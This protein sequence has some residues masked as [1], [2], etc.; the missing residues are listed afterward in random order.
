[1]ISAECFMQLRR[2]HDREHL[3]IPQIAHV[4]KLNVKTVAAWVPL[5]HY[6]PRAKIKRPSKLDAH[7]ATVTRLLDQCG[8]SAVQVFQRLRTQGYTG[9]YSI[10][11]DYIREIRPPRHPAF[12]TL[13]YAPG[14]CA[15]V[16][17]GH[18]GTIAVG[19]THRKLSFLVVVLCYSRRMYVEFT[20]AQALEHFL[21]A[22]Q[23]ALLYFGA[24]PQT[25]LVDN[26]KTAVLEHVPGLPP[27]FHPRFLEFARHF[28]FS[29]KA[30]GVRQPQAK[31]RVENGVGYVKKNFLNGRDLAGVSAM[32]L[33][34]REWLDTVANVRVHRETHQTPNARF[35]AEKTALLPLNP[36]PADTGVIE[37][38]RVSHQC[39]VVLDTNRYS[40]PSKYASS[41]LSL[42]R[43]DERLWLY[44]Q[45]KLVADHVRSYDRRQ[46]IENPDHVRELLRHKHGAQDHVL[47]QRFLELSP[48]AEIFHR[49]ITA[50]ELNAPHHVRHIMAL[51][52][53]YP[54]EQV[55]QA[56]ENAHAL[57]SY[58][59]EYIAVILSMRNRPRTEPGP[60]H[61]TRGQELLDLELPP[62]DLDAYNRPN[63][64]E[65]D[66]NHEVR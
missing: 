47:L 41:R 31:G 43:T 56:L 39:R 17:W 11:K 44:H 2:L 60:L 45:Q 35:E 32:N 1:M 24:V 55:V 65:G 52:E 34:V 7:K 15:Q 13:A 59:A 9:G 66:T 64:T 33:A 12:L 38:V 30:C 25:V 62:P 53:I 61:L 27:V 54:K 50:R 5:T 18:A 48:V 42:R 14:E 63:T 57:G 8:Y 58:R 28:G 23:R 49:E 21:G 51:T 26:M 37:P 20:P 29:P 3:S 40:V 10:L 22:M 6:Q 46:N 36:Q 4:L 16:D 19:T